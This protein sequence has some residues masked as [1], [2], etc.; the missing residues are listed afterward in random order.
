[1]MPRGFW[2]EAE[3]ID[4]VAAVLRPQA[5]AE[6]FEAKAQGSMRAT[7]RTMLQ[8]RSSTGGR[9]RLRALR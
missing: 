9:G 7:F 1:M 8:R 4:K 3:G 2:F 5:S 6:G